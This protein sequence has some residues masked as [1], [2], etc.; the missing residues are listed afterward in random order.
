MRLIEEL[1]DPPNRRFPAGDERAIS[2]RVTLTEGV[3]RDGAGFPQQR[4]GSRTGSRGHAGRLGGISTQ[5]SSCGRSGS[6]RG[7]P[8]DRDYRHH[9]MHNGAYALKIRSVSTAPPTD[10][11]LSYQVRDVIPEH[12]RRGFILRC[13]SPS[14]ERSPG[15]GTPRREV[16]APALRRVRRL[17][18]PSPSSAPP[19]D[20]RLPGQLRR[21]ASR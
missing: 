6:V 8:A 11:P 9:L 3:D 20:P 16:A 12:R 10:P 17:L 7:I 2:E 4:E 5:S 18:P 1:K 13:A 14:S 21:P 19:S 15:P